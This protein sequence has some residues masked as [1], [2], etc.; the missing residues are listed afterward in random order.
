MLHDFVELEKVA[1]AQK[2][3]M[4]SRAKEGTAIGKPAA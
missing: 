4:E 2:L 1:T 3:P